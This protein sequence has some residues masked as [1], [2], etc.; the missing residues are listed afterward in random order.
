MGEVE[1]IITI[2]MEFNAL[3]K[4]AKNMFWTSEIQFNWKNKKRTI[5][6]PWKIKAPLVDSTSRISGKNK[7]RN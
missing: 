5:K 1:I 4:G 3:Q 6:I 2:S 7:K